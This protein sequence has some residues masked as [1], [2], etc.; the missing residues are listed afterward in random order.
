MKYISLSKSKF[1]F[2]ICV[3]SLNIYSSNISY[4]GEIKRIKGTN[5]F[6]PF[7]LIDSS[8]QKIFMPKEAK[9]RLT[10]LP[11]FSLFKDYIQTNYSLKT[12]KFSD[13]YTGQTYYAGIIKNQNEMI[14]KEY[15]SSDI[16]DLAI[17][18]F[19]DNKENI[20]SFINWF[21]TDSYGKRILKP[22]NNKKSLKEHLMDEGIFIDKIT[23]IFNKEQFEFWV[24]IK[25]TWGEKM[26]AVFTLK[27]NKWNN[28]NYHCIDCD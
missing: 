2:L 3:L 24:S 10:L 19:E 6:I 21:S 16:F 22:Y 13:K 1:F 20:K 8:L 9:L 26:F 15:V 14:N 18:T 12:I 4:I 7:V 27:N 28:I 23:H 11:L 5:M 25:L 17:L